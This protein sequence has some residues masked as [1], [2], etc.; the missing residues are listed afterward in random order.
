M[1]KKITILVIFLFCLSL[2]TKVLADS[3][4]DYSW[5]K[6]MDDYSKYQ[7]D[8]PVTP[9]AEKQALET[10]QKY[11]KKKKD[12]HEGDDEWETRG[13]GIFKHKVKKMKGNSTER[14]R[15]GRKG[16]M[17]VNM[18]SS[19]PLLRLPINV[20]FH[21]QLIENGFYLVT[22]FQYQ[23]KFY[24]VLKQG[25][26]GTIYSIEATPMSVVMQE[27]VESNVWFYN[28]GDYAEIVYTNTGVSLR[29]KLMFKPERP[30]IPKPVLIP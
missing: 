11:K 25:Q 23:G 5:D 21:N 24:L 13:W 6:I 8:K 9:Q 16:Q 3:D 17:P 14:M 22:Y 10:L 12:K 4:G 18:A 20:Y 28:K 30:V 15:G 29:A 26:K 7:I 27:A 1:S 19:D 2:Q